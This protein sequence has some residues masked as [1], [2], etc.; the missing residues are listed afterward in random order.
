MDIRLNG[1]LQELENWIYLLSIIVT[2]NLAKVDFKKLGAV[3]S[4]L[5]T[6]SSRDYLLKYLNYPQK[7]QNPQS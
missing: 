5:E 6:T 7:R 2:K 4:L 1:T 3:L